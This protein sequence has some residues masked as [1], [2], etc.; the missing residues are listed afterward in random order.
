MRVPSFGRG[1]ACER[2][3]SAARAASAV[4][5][6]RGATV[7]GGVTTSI[8]IRRALVSVSDKG[9]LETLAR[10]LVDCK[11]EVLSTG[12]TYRALCELGVAVEKVS[13]YTGAPEI[14][15]GRVKT[16]HPRI[17]GGI[18]AAPTAEH[19]Q[20]RE[21]HDIPAIDLVVVNLYPF[22]EVIRDPG[23]DLA[24]AV[25]NIDIGGPTMVRA[26]AKNAARVTVIV[27]PSDYGRVGQALAENGGAVPESLR[28]DL[29]RKAF[30]HTAAY[31]AAIA[32][33]L[34]GEADT[35]QTSAPPV[36]FA[37]G[38][39]HGTLRYGENPH[40]VAGL[41]AVAGEPDEAPGLPQALVLQGKALSYNNLLDA[42]AALG[43][44]RDLQP[45]GTAAAVFKHASPCGAA[46][47]RAGES[48]A[49]VYR[50]AREADAESAFGGIVSVSEQVDTATA[51]QIAETF[52]EVVIAPGYST[53]AREVLARK[54]NL[55]LL[56]LPQMFAAGPPPWRLRSV[57]GGVL[58]QREDVMHVG[59]AAASVATKTTPT[60]EQMIDLEVA[61]RV[62]KHV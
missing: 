53:G 9:N 60:A 40:Q 18:L 30:A 25:E 50:K 42:D 39:R 8:P 28:R 56:E 51:E 48:L 16:L 29:A 20:E 21:R 4:D 62:A 6:R 44:I 57:A 46:V 35:E 13:D 2:P 34:A 37:G 32:A 38:P 55:R 43:I 54:K 52:I 45:L 10:V 7:R 12:G 1:C 23:C 19:D 59:A 11:V 3:G 36:V 17:H 14:L 5:P 31:D 27:D 15:G 49:E 26:A 24:R 33:Y 22:R 47:G 61:W 58:L 41:Y